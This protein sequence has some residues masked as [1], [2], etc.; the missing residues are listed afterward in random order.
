MVMVMGYCFHA[1]AKVQLTT[2]MKRIP[3]VTLCLHHIVSV[4]VTK[5]YLTL[6]Y[7]LEA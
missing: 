5:V 6:L 3:R 4:F 2:I 1:S 7:T